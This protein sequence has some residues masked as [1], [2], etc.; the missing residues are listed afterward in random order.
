MSLYISQ[1]FMSNSI[2]DDTQRF[3]ALTIRLDV[4]RFKKITIQLT[5]L[6][7][8]IGSP[9]RWFQSYL[10]NGTQLVELHF[11][12]HQ[13]IQTV[14]ASLQRMPLGSALRPMLSPYYQ[15]PTLPLSR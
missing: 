7:F 1:C 2:S 11:K 12:S 5:K 6:E 3:M 13:K 4:L 15:L 8:V 10:S 14:I 9:E